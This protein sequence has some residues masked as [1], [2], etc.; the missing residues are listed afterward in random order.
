[1]SM[2]IPNL[3]DL[4][5]QQLIDTLVRSI[6]HY[7]GQWTDFNPSE[8]GITLL[9]ML[10]WISQ[11]LLYRANNISDL[12][13]KN[14]LKL[15]AGERS[16]EPND[17]FH[18]ALLDELEHWPSP[19]SADGISTVTSKVQEYWNSTNRVIAEVDYYALS[20]EAYYAEQAHQ[21]GKAFNTSINYRQQSMN[22]L[23]KL[24]RI[25]VNAEVKS[26][27]ES[28][29]KLIEVIVNT[30][31]APLEQIQIEPSFELDNKQMLT[32]IKNFIVPRRP[33]GTMI[34][35]RKVHN[36]DIELKVNVVFTSSSKRHA[37]EAAIMEQI[38]G[39]VSPFSGGRDD[40]G[41]PLSESLLSSDLVRLIGEV[42]G[43]AGVTNV[44]LCDYLVISKVEAEIPVD[45]IPQDA[46]VIYY[47]QSPK[48]S[49]SGKS[50]KSEES[51]EI[52]VKPRDFL[53]VQTQLS[54]MEQIATKA[55]DF[56]SSQLSELTE[57]SATLEV[58]EKLKSK[59]KT[60]TKKKESAAAMLLTMTNLSAT[61]QSTAQSKAE[62]DE[63]SVADKD[64]II[65]G[66]NVSFGFIKINELIGKVKIHFPSELLTGANNEA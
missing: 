20:L 17:R 34:K 41:W 28:K 50:V 14:Y 57:A 53:L 60:A 63:V 54:V 43:V 58:K 1:M 59:V 27:Q 15:I 22:H 38:K 19:Q 12:S 29:I 2:E 11:S 39:Y 47:K 8:P 51:W 7:S 65:E 6:P 44:L 36:T 21:L 45:E 66:R 25:F 33:V 40:S 18:A 32:A 5:Y 42:D 56:G 10:S 26:E 31:Q 61:A 62:G 16:Y 35:V 64:A 4:T 30:A 37:V 24:R 3:D 49:D 52:L 13:Y 55:A 48:A 9:E 46:L 23:Q